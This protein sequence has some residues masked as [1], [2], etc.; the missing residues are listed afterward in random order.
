MGLYQVY[1]ANHIQPD[2]S[3]MARDLNEEHNK[4]LKMADVSKLY[5][6]SIYK[7]EG[8]I[9]VSSFFGCNIIISDDKKHNPYFIV[10][11][12][13]ELGLW[14]VT[15]KRKDQRIF[16]VQKLLLSL[17]WELNKYNPTAYRYYVNFFKESMTPHNFVLMLSWAKEY[18]LK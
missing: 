14:Y 1:E 4:V 8:Y 17:Y 9:E 7:P 11:Q 5:L 18:V 13:K 10:R 3:I 6:K 16:D 2:L 12:E 15:A